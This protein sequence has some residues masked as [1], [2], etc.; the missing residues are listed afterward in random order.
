MEIKIK[1]SSLFTSCDLSFHASLADFPDI[2]KS[3]TDHAEISVRCGLEN[4]LVQSI[5]QSPILLVLNKA[6]EEYLVS[7]KESFISDQNYCP[8]ESFKMFSDASLTSIWSETS[9]IELKLPIDINEVH[10]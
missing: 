2:T 6:N 7:L 8:I 4:V 1:T 5:N 10:L 3:S 9:K